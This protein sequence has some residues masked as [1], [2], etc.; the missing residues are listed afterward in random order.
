MAYISDYTFNNNSR[1]GDDSCDISQRNT[2]NSGAANYSLTNF[3]P[4]CPMS[5]A[6]TF[7]TS[8]PNI[9]FSGSNQV[10]IGGCNIDEN[11]ELHITDITKPKCRISLFQRPF[12]T[13]PFV[14]R[15]Q[16]NPVLESQ[17]QQGELANNRKTINPI[18][19]VSY[20]KYSQTPM[21]PSLKATI[22]NPSNLVEG[23]AAK[24][25]IR[26]GVPS[27]ELTR[28]EDYKKTHTKNQYV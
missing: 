12:A 5:D 10:G 15:G 25:W 21:I 7:A 9:N 16:S 20:E 4:A 6:V 11:S 1:L 17:L 27:R 26:G 8:Q 24:G 22:N 14:G 28:D 23:V 18:S 13:V 3:R 19:E 2:Q